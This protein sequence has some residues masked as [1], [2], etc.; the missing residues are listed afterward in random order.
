MRCPINNIA[1]LTGGLAGE[2]PYQT[3]PST[4]TFTNQGTNGDVLTIVGT[5][6]TFIPLPPSNPGGLAGEVLY[7]SAPSITTFSNQG[8]NGQVLTVVGSAPTFSDLPPSNPGGLSGE[9]LYQSSPS[10]TTFTNQGTDGQEL[11]I[12]GTT[13][14]FTTKPPS[15]PGGLSGEVLY[16]S[17]PSVTTFTNQGTNGQILQ[18]VSSIPTFVTVPAIH[19]PTIFSTMTTT[20]PN[21][22]PLPYVTPAGCHYI[23]VY[24][25]AGG[26]GAG[27]ASGFPL[28]A[29][30]LA[31]GGGGS[32]FQGI[33]PA[34][35]YQYRVGIGGAGG[36]CTASPGVS[37]DFGYNG[38]PSHWITGSGQISLY[39]GGRGTVST[40]LTVAA[41][42]SGGNHNNA[43]SYNVIFIDGG[44]GQDGT[45]IPVPPEVPYPVFSSGG[46]T[47]FAPAAGDTLDN[48]FGPPGTGRGGGGGGYNFI[49]YP[50]AGQIRAPDGGSG[51]LYIEE[52]Y[53]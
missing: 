32:S 21:D 2:V 10:N 33:F 31:G 1:N 43:S 37:P 23:R 36:F 46:G 26:G 50:S 4:T 40:I 14:T 3:A 34:G 16:Q 12:V 19:T 38:D 20:S 11:T 8:T 5:A 30:W 28:I 42:G 6:P 52:Y 9:V 44:D 51:I 17:S 13:P 22:D 45:P 48:N 29:S 41:G 39:G 27:A 24:M 49:T 15:N 53:Q 35:N 7:Q 47:Y 25:V 18:I